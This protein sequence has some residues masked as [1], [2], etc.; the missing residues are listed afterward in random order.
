[1]FFEIDIPKDD[2]RIRA[3]D[4]P[5]G[6][7]ISL[8]SGTLDLDNYN[9]KSGTYD[10]T[11]TCNEQQNSSEASQ[12][13]KKKNLLSKRIANQFFSA[14]GDDFFPW[15]GLSA[16]FGVENKTGHQIPQ[17]LGE[18]KIQ[19]IVLGTWRSLYI[20]E[21]E[22]YKPYITRENVAKALMEGNLDQKFQEWV[23]LLITKTP[24]QYTDELVKRGFPSIH[25]VSLSEWM[26]ANMRSNNEKSPNTTDKIQN[27]CDVCSQPT[28]NR[29]K[30]CKRGRFCTKEHQRMYWTFHKIS[31]KQ[32]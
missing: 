12:I 26:D 1:M 16:L 15:Y 31:C 23:E 19:D 9:W 20:S 6:R 17:N 30:N 4:D 10:D 2:K 7:F 13:H 29:C 27:R 25:W 32:G 18:R 8:Y 14:L 11:E 5:K 22:E 21:I 28:H 24:T 3:C